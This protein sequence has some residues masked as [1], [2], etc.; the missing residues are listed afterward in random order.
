MIIVNIPS[1]SNNKKY[2]LIYDTKQKQEREK[3]V[4]N[5]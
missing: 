2:W 5:V 4:S 3:G 1:D